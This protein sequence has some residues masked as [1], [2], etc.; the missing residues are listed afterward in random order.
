MNKKGFL[1][2]EE[3]LKIV[4]AVICI[5]FL[6]F[7]LVSVYYAVTGGQKSKE[8]ASI[9]NG[10]NGLTKEIERINL[11]GT[12]KPD[13][14]FVPNPVSWYVFSFIGEDKKP[15]LCTGKDCLCIC[16]NIIINIFDRQIKDCDDKGACAIVQNLKGFNKIGIDRKGIWLSIE[17]IN[18]EIEIKK[19]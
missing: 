5:I 14:F 4:V 2:G 18:G 13:G 6:I 9:L 3:T 19:K 17:K 10:A 1:L 12:P 8:A 7:L 16:K 11:G 15:N